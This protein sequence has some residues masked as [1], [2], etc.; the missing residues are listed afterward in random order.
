MSI[1][2]ERITILGTPDF[3]AFLNAEASKE[4][5]SVSELVRGRCQA[6]PPSSDEIMLKELIKTANQASKR[7]TEKLS[8]SISNVEAILAELGVVK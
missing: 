3:K 7:A 5:V 4:G 1:K 8:K 2:S 6:V